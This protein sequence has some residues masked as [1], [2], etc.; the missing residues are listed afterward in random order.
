MKVEIVFG[1]F[2]ILILI[3]SGC[4]SESRPEQ[5]E[6]DGLVVS[7]HCEDRVICYNSAYYT[8]EAGCFRDDDLVAKYC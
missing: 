6:R 4:S 7:T 1:L 3:I 8:G 2:M 5:I